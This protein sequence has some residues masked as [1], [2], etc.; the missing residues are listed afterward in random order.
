MQTK[1]AVSRCGFEAKERRFC[2]N[3]CAMAEKLIPN[4]PRFPL[5]TLLSYRTCEER[6]QILRRYRD[7]VRHNHGL[8]IQ[9]GAQTHGVI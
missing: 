1:T 5:R 7:L 2:K 6:I 8:D 9:F 3:L 4:A